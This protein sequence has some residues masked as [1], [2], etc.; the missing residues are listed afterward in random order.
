MKLEV[1]QMYFDRFMKFVTIFYNRHFNSWVWKC[2]YC[3]FK[4]RIIG[5]SNEDKFHS[6]EYVNHK[7]SSCRDTLEDHINFNHLK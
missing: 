3:K 2:N 4:T 6:P 5:R 1:K 7:R